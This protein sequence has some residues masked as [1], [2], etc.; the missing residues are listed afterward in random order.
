MTPSASVALAMAMVGD[1]YRYV[2]ELGAGGGGTVIVA[3]HRA[4]NRLVAV[5]AVVTASP[6]AVSRLRREGRALAA[7]NHPS[8]LRVWRLVDDGSVVALVT[9]YLD[10]GDFEAAL[11]NDVLA[12]RAVVDVLTRVGGALQAAHGAGVV[13]RDVKPSNVLLSTT[14]RT[15][16][17]DFGLTRLGGEFRTQR[18]AITGTPMYMAPEQITDPDTES[19]ALDVYS[20][21][22]L[23][24][25]ALTG[26]PPFAAADLK[27]LAELHLTGRPQSPDAVR[28]GI[29]K[30]VCGVVLGMLEKKPRN[31]PHL[32]EALAALDRVD[33][34]AWDTVLPDARAV[35]GAPTDSSVGAAPGNATATTRT[36][37]EALH[38]GIGTEVEDAPDVAAETAGAVVRNA[39]AGFDG[40]Q[41]TLVQ[42]VYVLK[43]RRRMPTRLLILGIGIAVG[44]VV[45]LVVLMIM[46]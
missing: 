39:G 5:K 42:P 9:E 13:H 28:A 44:L 1:G 16:L 36:A 18:G 2:G 38:V 32:R 11:A 29:P 31:R 15:V 41:E 12:G 7:L 20:Y 34:A 14:G 22:A 10:G 30:A 8:I 25:R 19:A 21:G 35:E 37:T 27:T 40:L 17:A 3:E 26:R 45:G 46:R 4:M 24:Y 43:R 33:P 6:S 23:T